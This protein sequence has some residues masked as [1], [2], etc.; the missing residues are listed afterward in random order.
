MRKNSQSID[1]VK[2]LK[3][4]HCKTDFQW[5]HFTKS[6]NN[7]TFRDKYI[8]LQLNY[9]PIVL[10]IPFVLFSLSE[11]QVAAILKS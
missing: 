1:F 5:R 6:R 8:H 3:K 10:L 11:F 2:N 7:Y 4:K 9:S